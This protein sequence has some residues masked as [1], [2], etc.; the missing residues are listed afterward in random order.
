MSTLEVPEA[1]D[2]ASL[3][4]VKSVKPSPDTLTKLI[5]RLRALTLVLLPVEV[6]IADINGATSRVITPQVISAYQAAAGDFL[7]ALPY[8]LLRARA[9]FMWDANNNPSDYGENLK[10]GIACEVLAR[11]VV[12]IAPH[13]RLRSIMSCRFQ[14]RLLDGEKSDMTSALEIA[15]DSHWYQNMFRIAIWLFFLVVYSQAVREPLERLGDPNPRLDAWEVILYVMALSYAMEDL[16]KFYLLIRF[17]SLRAVSFWNVVAFLTDTILVA[18]FA[19]RVIGMTTTDADSAGWRL[20]SFQVLSTVAPLICWNAVTAIIL[21]NILISLFSS[22]YSDVIDDAEGQYLAFFASKTI[23]MIRAPDSFVYPAPFNLVETFLVAPFE[24]ILNENTYNTLNRYV[25]GFLF[26]IPLTVIAL[27]EA[28]YDG[29]KYSWLNAWLHGED[30]GSND[31]PES[32]DPEVDEAEHNGLKISKV[33]FAELISVFPNTEKSSEAAI[34]Q[35]IQDLKVLVA[36]L[37]QKLEA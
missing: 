16:H 31:Y 34:I 7:E 20:T 4:S 1:G 25:M 2:Q 15:I 3:L 9:E 33:P 6:D 11:R 23:G 36:R 13:E 27:C 22:A 26:C 35:E 29:Q 12:H 17:S 21:L 32:R 18:A 8:C 24:S 30:E 10:R 37:V 14:H 19:L 5:K 28:S